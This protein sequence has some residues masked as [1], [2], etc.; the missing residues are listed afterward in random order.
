[1]ESKEFVLGGVTEVAVQQQYFFPGLGQHYPQ[2]A[3][4]GTFAFIGH[5]AGDLHH[6]HFLI[7][8]AELQVGTDGAVGFR[9]RALGILKGQQVDFFYFSFCM[10]RMF[11]FYFFHLLYAPL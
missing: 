3:D 7:H 9:Y 10:L 8:P 5:R 2:T 6:F 11:L 4:Y 1:M